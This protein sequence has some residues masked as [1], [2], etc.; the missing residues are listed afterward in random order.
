MPGCVNS[1]KC[2]HGLKWKS[3]LGH[4]GRRRD[5]TRGGEAA[6]ESDEAAEGVGGQRGGDAHGNPG[7][8]RGEPGERRQGHGQGTPDIQRIQP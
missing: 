2:I 1:V 4:R 8:R 7:R 3:F 5:P 6:E